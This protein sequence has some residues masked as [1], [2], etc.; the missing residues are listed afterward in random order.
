[1]KYL[2]SVQIFVLFFIAIKVRA[3]DRPQY[4]VDLIPDSLKKNASAVVREDIGAFEVNAP[5]DATYKYK[6]VVTILKE[7]NPYVQFSRGYN[8]NSKI[9]TMRAR[10]YDA[11]GKLIRKVE[12]DEIRDHAAYDGISLCTDARVK[13]VDND[14]GVLP[15]TFEIEYEVQEKGF[16][17]FP[18]WSFQSF[19][20]SVQH[21]EYFISVP[22]TTKVNH[23]VA[24]ATLQPLTRQ[25]ENKHTYLW[26]MDNLKAVTYESNLPNAYKILPR[27]EATTNN[28]N[29]YDVTGDMSSWEGFAKFEASLNRDRDK[30]SPAMALRV[31]SMVE[32]CKTNREK[33][34]TLYHYLQRNMRYVSVQLGIGGF[35]TFDAAYVEKNKYGDCKALSNFMKSMLKVVDIEAQAS[36]VYGGEDDYFDPDP[37]F[38]YDHFNHVILYIPSEKMWLECTSD[39]LPTGYLSTFT[40]NRGALVFNDST[41]KIVRTP[42]LDTTTNI[43]I[44]K[45][46]IQLAIDGSATLNN[47][48]ILQGS[49]QDH[50]RGWVKNL[51]KEEIQKRF[52]QTKKLPTFKIEKLEMSADPNKPEV[53][54][55]YTF[56]FEKFGSKAGSRLIIPINADNAF[57]DTPPPTEKRNFPIEAGGSGYTQNVET[58]LNIPDG[59]T[60]E[61]LPNEKTEMHSIYGSYVSSIE[62][63]EKSII[64][65]RK[66]VIKP[67]SQPAEKFNEFRDFYKKMEQADAAKVILKAK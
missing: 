12:K 4:A 58:T 36:V 65:K 25:N 49:L 67:V 56:S 10:Y 41:G 17:Q 26:Q 32:N 9:K 8:K 13:T 46:T 50:F 57:D 11:S 63:T 61:A 14:Y 43:E 48:S 21:S 54:V 22:A 47:N 33:I 34:D 15:Y 5:D 40:Q 66:L 29:F 31:K 52:Q 28:F 19:G 23:R 39:D 1:M 60:I 64:F 6:M 38:C 16:F 44:T 2:V 24:N 3:Q 45:S 62:K 18:S 53:K 51:S 27:V 20:A 30:L 37:N 55:D 42:A 35:Q 59:F 7:K